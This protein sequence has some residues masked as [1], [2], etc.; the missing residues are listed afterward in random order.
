[1]KLNPPTKTTIGLLL[2]STLLATTLTPVYAQSLN[3]AITGGKFSGQFRMRYEGVDQDNALIDADAL[4]LR[5]TLKYDSGI[6]NGF[7][8]VLEMEDVR[9][10]FGKDEYTV[11]PSGFNPGIYSVVADP[12][13]T[14]L[15]QGFLQYANGS[16]TAKLGRQVINLDNQ[17]FVGAVGWRQDWQTFDAF[18]WE[19]LQMHQML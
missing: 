11:G 12:D 5:S 8:A 3:E 10:M 13:T 6:Y 15:N 7:S 19:C 4:T 16:F 2:G 14:E 9:S 18:F 17:R 1:M